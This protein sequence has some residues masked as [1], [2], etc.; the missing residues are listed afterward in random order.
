MKDAAE[1]IRS[2][3]KKIFENYMDRPLQ[4]VEDLLRANQEQIAFFTRTELQY[5]ANLTLKGLIREPANPKPLEI[6]LRDYQNLA[7]KYLKQLC[8]TSRTYALENIERLPWDEPL[9][10]RKVTTLL[11]NKANH[12]HSVST[13]IAMVMNIG[14]DIR[15]KAALVKEFLQMDG[16]NGGDFQDVLPAYLAFYS[17][18][19]HFRNYLAKTWQVDPQWVRNTLVGWRRKFDPWLPP[20]VQIEPLTAFMAD[21]ARY[22]GSF[23]CEDREFKII[24][25]LQQKHSLHLLP[26]KMPLK[27]LLPPKYQKDFDG[28][29][30][31]I[32]FSQEIREKIN[33]FTS[34]IDLDLFA[35][36]T[37]EL[38]RKIRR[39]MTALEEKSPRF[40]RTLTFLNKLELL[41]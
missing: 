21:L 1:A 8:R 7:R 22:C 23:C 11:G 10:E 30:E 38:S 19:I 36:L 26:T 13:Q 12:L 4:G 25:I 31:K 5:D 2:E 41:K 33:E 27:S 37:G 15:Q 20:K 14:N 24:G 17:V 9:T 16:D 34:S 3:Y 29:R 40:K 18:P 6:S 32:I 35:Q 28:L 39:H